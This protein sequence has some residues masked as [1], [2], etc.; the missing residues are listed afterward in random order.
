MPDDA[1]PS[2][3]TSP[4]GSARA[5]DRL[6]ECR[7]LAVRPDD[8]DQLPRSRCTDTC[9]MSD[10]RHAARTRSRSEQAG[11]HL[12]STGTSCPVT[13]ASVPSSR[14]DTG[15]AGR[16]SSAE[17]G[18]DDLPSAA[19]YLGCPGDDPPSAMHTTTRIEDTTSMSPTN[20]T[21]TPSAPGRGCGPAA[22]AQGAPP[23]P[24]AR[25]ASGSVAPSLPVR[26]RAACAARPRAPARSSP[27]RPAR[28]TD[29]LGGAR[30]ARPP[31]APPPPQQRRRGAPDSGRWPRAA[32]CP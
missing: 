15:R 11:A 1:L 27:W 19:T 14:R 17:V 13:S 4:S 30:P 12:V 2:S 7:L 10:A 29:D 23:P 32:R 21:V 5:E 22:T 6:D 16:R 25:P 18:L 24:S 8:A 3:S 20:S 31:A 26:A 9:R 28:P